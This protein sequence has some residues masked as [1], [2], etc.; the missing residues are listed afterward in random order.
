ME[1]A[2]LVV[3]ILGFVFLTTFVWSISYDVRRFQELNL[4]RQK[5]LIGEAGEAAKKATGAAVL[6]LDRQTDLDKRTTEFYR[7]IDLHLQKLDV[8]ANS[9]VIAARR[10]ELIRAKELKVALDRIVTLTTLSRQ[11]PDSMYLEAIESVT[12]RIEDLEDILEK[13]G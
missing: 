12:K 2:I 4:K 8:L 6:V 1:I 3:L 9:D 7:R 10:D 13:K 11:Q 5:Q